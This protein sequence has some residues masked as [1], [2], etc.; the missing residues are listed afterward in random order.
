ME[1]TKSRNFSY[2]IM[3]M[4]DSEYLQKI[5][6]K[7][8]IYVSENNRIEGIIMF[9]NTKTYLSVYK[10]LK[11]E[12]IS[13]ELNILQTKKITDQIISEYKQKDYW[14]NGSMAYKKYERKKN[15]ELLNE[16]IMPIANMMKGLTVQ[17]HDL[18]FQNKEI[19]TLHK[20]L[21][22]KIM[23]PS[24]TTTIVN[25][26]T[27]TNHIN[28]FNIQI[29]LN[30][31]CKDAINFQDFIDNIQI[32][33]SDLIFAKDHGF[34]KSIVN[35]IE[36]ELNKCDIHTRPLHCTDI[37]RDILHIREENKWIKENGKDSQKIQKAIRNISHKKNKKAVEFFKTYPEYTDP[38][39]QKYNDYEPILFNVMCGYGDEYKKNM[40]KVIHELSK[41]VHISGDNEQIT[42]C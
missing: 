10:L 37:K 36:K 39:S 32:E 17:N 27:T 11:T 6:C 14:D 38:K 3:N 35:V 29:F 25:N 5:D 19:T 7:Y 40:N 12:K 28:K 21:L 31:K 16:I 26:T 2:K 24:T 41:H 30:E 33:D 18:V 15:S 8:Q 23:I 4:I 1:K 42:A 34:V 22:E 9:E 20:E 13:L